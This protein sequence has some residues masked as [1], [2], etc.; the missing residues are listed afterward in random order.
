[1]ACPQ[2]DDISG[3]PRDS[4][5]RPGQLDRLGPDD[6]VVKNFGV[7]VNSGAGVE[8]SRIDEGVAQVSS[9]GFDGPCSTE[10]LAVV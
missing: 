3:L 8:E 6:L 7:G 5:G 2:I 1:L 10:R 9:L 4:L